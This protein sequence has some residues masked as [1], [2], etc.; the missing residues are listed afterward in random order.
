MENL[1]GVQIAT[2][3]LAVSGAAL[4]ALSW[5]ATREAAAGRLARGN[6]M[7]IRVARTLSS[8]E[9]WRRGHEVALPWTLTARY[10]AGL[11]GVAALVAIGLGHTTPAGLTLAIGGLLSAVALPLAAVPA[12]NRDSLDEASTES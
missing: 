7:G 3:V 12:I 4:S 10:V 1:T 6:A 11:L 9:A 5:W 2:I 8:D